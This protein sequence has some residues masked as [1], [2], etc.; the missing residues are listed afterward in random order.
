MQQPSG[1]APQQQLGG[2]QA[3]PQQ[4][5]GYG[6]YNPQGYAPQQPQQQFGGYGGYNPQG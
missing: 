2:Q 1:Y 5:G 3:A 4:F 6:G